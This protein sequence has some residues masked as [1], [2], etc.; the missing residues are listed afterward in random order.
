MIRRLEEDGWQLA[1]MKGSHR[2]FRHP[3][4]PKLVT[5]AGK[6]GVDVPVGTLKNIR[7]QAEIEE[8]V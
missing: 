2:R 7:R 3:T 6:P 1:R 4:K 8:N 5:V